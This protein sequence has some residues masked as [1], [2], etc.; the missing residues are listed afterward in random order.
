M[1]ATFDNVNQLLSRAPGGEIAFR[2][3]IN[4]PASVG[5]AGQP[6]QTA[7]DNTFTAQAPVSSGT[8]NVVVTATDP[9]GNVRTN[10]YQVSNSG[11]AV[12]YTYDSNG[13]LS[14]K[15]EGTDAWGYEWNALNQLTRVTKNSIEQARFAYD[16]RGRRVEKVAASV[17]TAYAYDDL[18][19]LRE[20]RGATT[21]RYVH[22]PRTD[23]PLAADDGAAITYFHADGLGSIVKSTTQTGTVELTRQY[24]TWGT[25]ELGAEQQ[26]Y[27]FT[28]RE[29]D[30]EIALYY[31]RARY[32][33]PTA[34]RFT[35]P[36]PI[37]FRSGVNFYQYVNANPANGRDPSGLTVLPIGCDSRAITKIMQA[38]VDARAAIYRC[39]G[40]KARNDI[41]KWHKV[42]VVQCSGDTVPDVSVP[43][44]A[45]TRNKFLIQL[46]TAGL[47]EEPGC[48]CLAATIT[49]EMIHMLGRSNADHDVGPPAGPYR[50]SEFS[51][52]EACFKYK[53]GG[54]C[55]AW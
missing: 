38:D 43:A 1:G 54:G 24:D 42:I 46:S 27:A 18:N 19:I 22:G 52:V 17:T 53:P 48:M 55:E 2:G 26:G 29:W 41:D 40:C 20:T 44:C 32:Y 49:H 3:S 11:A 16:P 10:T 8:S 31:Y 6:A 14:T 33:D 15:T 50:H 34:A 23:E 13:N 28:S 21:R 36:D 39:V 9:A 30:P 35:G 37:G 45:A 12:T 7:A 51:E 5:V 4:E 47:N 25:L